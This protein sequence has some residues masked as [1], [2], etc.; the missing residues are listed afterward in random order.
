[1]E[2]MADSWGGRVRIASRMELMRLS[3]SSAMASSRCCG[4]TSMGI[5]L[6]L[7]LFLIIS[8]YLWH[9]RHCL[10]PEPRL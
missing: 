5:V 6:R 1:M 10:P 4:I 2:M 8:V 3:E 9:D 7:A